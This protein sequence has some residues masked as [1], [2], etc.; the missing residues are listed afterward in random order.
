MGFPRAFNKE[1]TFTFHDCDL[2]LVFSFHYI[3]DFI[4]LS[5][6][7]SYFSII[8]SSEFSKIGIGTP[9]YS[10]PYIA[11]SLF[12]LSASHSPPYWI[13]YLILSHIF[14]ISIS[15]SFSSLLTSSYYLP[16]TYILWLSLSPLASSS[17]FTFLTLPL[18][19]AFFFSFFLPHSPPSFLSLV[20]KISCS[21]WIRTTPR[22]QTSL[23]F[24]SWNNWVRCF[25]L[26]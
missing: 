7:S 12:F 22:C 21:K 19:I 15:S 24:N 18:S 16:T 5:S 14:S 1:C 6:F 9:C 17:A 11:S 3:I 20:T 4:T 2:N 13:I 10:Q 8:I 26:N 25:L 23:Q